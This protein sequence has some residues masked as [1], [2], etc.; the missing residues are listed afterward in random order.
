MYNCIMESKQKYIYKG[1][2]HIHTKL[3]D[4]TE[5]VYSVAKAAKKAGLDWIIITDHNYYDQEEG[6]INSVYVIKGQEISP[7]SCNH[8][9]AIGLNEV[10]P[11]NDN[12]EVYVNEVRKKEGFG[13]S[14]HPDEGYICDN[15]GNIYPRKNSN[16]CIPWTD[17]NIKPDGVEIWNWFS[18]WADNLDDSNIFKLAYAYLFKHNIVTSPSKLTLNWWDSLNKESDKIV[19]AIGGVDAHALKFYRYII[20]VTV[21]PYLTCFKTITNHIGLNEP[22]S[23][24]FQTAKTQIFNALKS[25]QNIIMNRNTYKDLP[26][27]YA[28]DGE[29]KYFCGE[30]IKLNKNCKLKIKAKNDLN[31]CLIY[32]GI[33]IEKVLSDNFEIPITQSG[34]YRLEISYRNKG[35]LYTNPFNFEE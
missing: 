12:P 8:Y 5:D 14:A 10:I 28:S 18:N 32:N 15:G 34:K 35:F 23:K 25:G 2:V 29:N 11:I 20:P 4:G 13:F 27:I 21:F 6:I 19:P 16:H 17:K 22:L 24:D 33:G 30:K 1:A 31:V 7:K 3:S 9:I 26:E